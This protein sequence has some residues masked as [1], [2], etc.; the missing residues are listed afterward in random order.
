MKAVIKLF[1]LFYFLCFTSISLLALNRCAMQPESSF[2][3]VQCPFFQE[4]IRQLNALFNIKDTFAPYYKFLDEMNTE[5]VNLL[6]L[7][8]YLSVVAIFITGLYY[9]LKLQS[10]IIKISLGGIMILA[11]ILALCYLVMDQQQT[12]EIACRVRGIVEKLSRR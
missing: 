8:G 2:K 10:I 5:L 12:F 1:V 7:N 11:L 6:V 4:E 3:E 9:T